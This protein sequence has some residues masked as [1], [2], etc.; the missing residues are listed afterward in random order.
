MSIGTW[1]VEFRRSTGCL[2]KGSYIKFL[3]SLGS[4]VL[5][6]I[7]STSYK[8]TLL[9]DWYCEDYIRLRLLIIFI[10]VMIIII[11]VWCLH[12]H[13]S[14][15]CKHAYGRFA[16]QLAHLTCL[17][18]PRVRCSTF[19][20]RSFA[21]A[22]PTVWN[23]HLLPN[24]LRNPA[25]GLDQFR[26]NLTP[27][28]VCLLLAFRW[29][30]VRGVLR[31]RAIHCTFTYLLTQTALVQTNVSYSGGRTGTAYRCRVNGG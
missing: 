18:V 2:Y 17:T 26:R 30:C 1:T 29:Q 31:V 11:D 20:C 25:V 22:D 28:P 12:S 19:G 5:P 14:L 13:D 21:S 27:I 23:S 4:T 16:R 9:Y 10:I 8:H 24:N 15:V 3:S 6:N 7:T